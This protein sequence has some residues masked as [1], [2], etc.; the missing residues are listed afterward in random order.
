MQLSASADCLP[1]TL[2]GQ[3]P[4]AGELWKLGCSR[5]L[6]GLLSPWEPK[7]R[8]VFVVGSDGDVGDGGEA[9]GDGDQS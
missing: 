8:Q 1:K 6:M 3:G 4:A 9:T 2:P 7:K 5:L